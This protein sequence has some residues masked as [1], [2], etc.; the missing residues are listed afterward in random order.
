MEERGVLKG[1]QGGKE[2]R[3]RRETRERLIA[4]AFD[5]FAE[6]G[7]S[8]ASVELISERAGY[9]RGAFYSNFSRKEELLLALAENE[10]DEAI[11]RLD[12]AINAVFDEAMPRTIEE[13]VSVILR[14]FLQLHQT[15]RK[16]LLFWRE[17]ELAALRDPQIAEM[18]IRHQQA[19]F[20]KLANMMVTTAQRVGKRFIVPPIDLVR[21]CS[22]IF[23]ASLQ[24]SFSDSAKSDA[25]DGLMT[26]IVPT[27]IMQ[28]TED[29]A[30]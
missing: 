26:S 29:A 2:T 8:G 13:A 16:W 10:H 28:L 6:V 4:A 5:V 21:A 30:G 7:V 11:E 27:L 12:S 3:R 15:S 22:G 23:E 17:F 14:G 20:E 25:S 1:V 18:Y 24:D 9:T 19:T